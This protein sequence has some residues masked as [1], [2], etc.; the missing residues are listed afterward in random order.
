MCQFF[1]FSM[2]FDGNIYH[3]YP[4]LIPLSR[5][6]EGRVFSAPPEILEFRNS[7]T[8]ISRVFPKSEQGQGISKFEY[9][10]SSYSNEGLGSWKFRQDYL[11][12]SHNRWHRDRAVKFCEYLQWDRV[13]NLRKLKD[14]NCIHIKEINLLALEFIQSNTPLNNITEDEAIKIFLETPD[15]YTLNILF[16][17]S[18]AYSI[19]AS[20][21][22]H[23]AF[24]RELQL[25]KRRNQIRYFT[26]LIPDL[27]T[28]AERKQ[29]IMTELW[30]KKKLRVAALRPIASCFSKEEI[31][32]LN[33]NKKI[34]NIRPSLRRIINRSAEY[35]YKR[36]WWRTQRPLC[37]PTSRQR[38]N[39]PYID[40]HKPEYQGEGS[41]PAPT[42][43]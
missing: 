20:K 30:N 27:F 4:E 43:S 11:A 22:G 10:F 35:L 37:G 23:D 18:N 36:S 40:Y 7:H 1:S 31:M 8:E 13:D 28:Y 42:T 29:I 2:D 25:L 9:V 38:G 41:I 34:S 33:R 16:R 19:I 17:N 5:W 6:D 32:W 26:S 12:P 3:L 24:L 39:P 21:I 14:A 15:A